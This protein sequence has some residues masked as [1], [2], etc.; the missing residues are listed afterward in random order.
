MNNSSVLTIS[1]VK[2]FIYTILEVKDHTLITYPL[3][4]GRGLR[5][6]IGGRCYVTVTVSFLNVYGKF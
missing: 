1:V 2:V 4:K 5:Q 3:K 6:N